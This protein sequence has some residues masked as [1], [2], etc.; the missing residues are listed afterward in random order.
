[1][2]SDLP[3]VAHRGLRLDIAVADIAALEAD[4]AARSTGVKAAPVNFT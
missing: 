1:M 4:A 3:S 2:P